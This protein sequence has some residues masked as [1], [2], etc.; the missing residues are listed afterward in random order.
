MAADKEEFLLFGYACRLFRDDEKALEI[1]Q[2]KH[3]IPWMADE[4]LKVDRYDA[5]GHLHSLHQHE[6][7][8]GGYDRYEG[9]TKEEIRIDK[10]CD[11][12]RYKSLHSDTTEE[13]IYLEEEWKRAAVATQDEASS[14]YNEI[15]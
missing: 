7:P 11:V 6:A 8:S 13:H 5:R 2:G 14:R 1:D 9:F 3:L 15:G 12:Q 4:K 10:L